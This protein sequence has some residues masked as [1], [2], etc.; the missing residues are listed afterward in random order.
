[1]IW[2]NSHVRNRKIDY[3][4]KKEQKMT[5]RS[6]SAKKTLCGQQGLFLAD[7]NLWWQIENITYKLRNIF[8]YTFPQSSSTKINSLVD[9]SCL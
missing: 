9:N 5:K 2:H 7:I 8:S 4:Y 6:F 1:M 3:I